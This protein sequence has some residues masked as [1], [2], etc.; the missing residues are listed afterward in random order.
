MSF[1]TDI[2]HRESCTSFGFLFFF[3]TFWADVPFA[4]YISQWDFPLSAFGASL[5]LIREQT[6]RYVQV[7][8]TDILA[9]Y[10]I[11]SEFWGEALHEPIALSHINDAQQ[12]LVVAWN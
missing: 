9:W 5:H 3:L 4:H 12:L 1:I 10:H 7:Q 2:G 6:S 8:H 11:A